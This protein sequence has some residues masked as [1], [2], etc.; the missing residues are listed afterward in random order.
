MLFDK[1]AFSIVYVG[2][3]LAGA[4]QMPMPMPGYDQLAAAA[5]MASM[6]GMS[7]TAPYWPRVAGWKLLKFKIFINIFPIV[8]ASLIFLSIVIEALGIRRKQKKIRSSLLELMCCFIHWIKKK[9]HQLIC[10]ILQCFLYGLYHSW[11]F[12]IRILRTSCSCRELLWLSV[13]YH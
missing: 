6:T 11:V 10:L 13:I 4:A 8:P 1:T 9:V 2:S 12:R 5:G 3:L 7:A